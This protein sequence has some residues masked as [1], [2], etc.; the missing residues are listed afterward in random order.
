MKVVLANGCFD[1]LHFGH[2]LHLQAARRLGDY[3]IV[4]LTTD[5]MAAKEKGPG[6]PIVGWQDRAM[7]LKALKCVSEV[8]PSSDCAKV[9][10][11]RQPD[12][13]AKGIDYAEYALPPSILKACEDVGAKIEITHTPKYSTTELIRRLKELA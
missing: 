13:F 12:I 8:V 4:S 7:M 6:R 9:I 3:L 10:L 1:C 5:E 2:V 11:E